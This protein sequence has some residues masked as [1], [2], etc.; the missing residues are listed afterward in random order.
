MLGG[1]GRQ[2]LAAGGRLGAAGQCAARGLFSVGKTHAD[3]QA[4]I[5]P[6]AGQRMMASLSGPPALMSRVLDGKMF[7]VRGIDV[8]MRRMLYVSASGLVVYGVYE[9][10]SM[11]TRTF[12]NMTIFDTGEIGFFAGGVVFSLVFIGGSYVIR[13]YSSVQPDQSADYGALYLLLFAS[14]C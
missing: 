13:R 2:L 7:Q 4:R 12:L 9:A 11:L 8:T 6:I 14:I 10:F 1:S 3:V 5:L